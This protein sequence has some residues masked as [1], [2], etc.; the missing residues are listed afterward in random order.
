MSSN[1]ENIKELSGGIII[2]RKSFQLYL[3][4]ETLESYCNTKA[5]EIS[6]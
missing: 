6:D 2:L 3:V 5:L 1:G 4:A